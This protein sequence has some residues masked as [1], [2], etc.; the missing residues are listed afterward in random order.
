MNDALEMLEYTTILDQI[1]EL[2]HTEAARRRAL[3]LRP[4]KDLALI[5]QRAHWIGQAA[6]CLEVSAPPLTAITGVEAA[7]PLLKLNEILSTDQL[8]KLGMFLTACRRMQLYLG[9][10]KE[11]A[12]EVAAWQFSIDALPELA[13][14][15]ER[16]IRGDDV[17]DRASPELRSVRCQAE[18]VEDRMRAKLESLLCAHPGWFADQFVTQRGGRLVLPLKKEHRREVAGSVADLSSSGSTVFIEPSS[19]GSMREE[20]EMLR[21]RER[22]EVQRILAELSARFA[23]KAAELKQN[24]ECLEEL[25]FYFACAALAKQQRAVEPRVEDLRQIRLVG[26]RQ[27]AAAR[28]ELRAAGFL[29]RHAAC[30]SGRGDHRPQHRRQDRR[31]QNRGAAL[32]DGADRAAR[33]LQG[34]LVPGARSGTVRFG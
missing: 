15:V 29:S 17:D 5:H 3:E 16:C 9:R 6:R 20:L 13:D 21:I 31:P 7:L 24:K 28:Q 27:S 23:E 1:A 26:A 4:T 32:P 10:M 18:I 34:G 8:T 2:T 19:V 33:S 11:T 14:E 12:S 25:D 22:N 30:G